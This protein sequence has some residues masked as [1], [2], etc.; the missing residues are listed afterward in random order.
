MILA[1][2]LWNLLEK[3]GVDFTY[4]GKEEECCGTPMLVAGKWDQFAEILKHNYNEV[5][6][7]GG[8]YG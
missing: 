7:A 4:L 8:K 5:K 1:K 3:I 2:L 6:K